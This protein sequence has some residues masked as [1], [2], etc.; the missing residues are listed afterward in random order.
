MPP[1]VEPP[2]GPA[3]EPP[4]RIYA[5]DPSGC[6]DRDDAFSI[7]PDYV[8]VYI[9]DVD[10][11]VRADSAYDKIIRERASSLYSPLTGLVHHMLAVDA[12][13][14]KND[15]WLVR[16]CSLT[17]DDTWKAVLKVELAAAGLRDQPSL[18]SISVT[19]IQMTRTLSYEG[20][21]AILDKPA[22]Q[23]PRWAREFQTDLKQLA[24]WTG[25]SE[26][27]ELV[28]IL[29]IATNRVVGQYLADHGY[30]LNRVCRREPEAAAGVGTEMA[31][32][33]AK[34]LAR[35]PAAYYSTNE[36]G[37]A[38]LGIDY[39]THFTSPMRRYPDLLAH[40]LV[41]GILAGR[42]VTLDDGVINSLN[43]QLRLIKRYY[44]K[45]TEH[46]LYYDLKSRETE[47]LIMAYPIAY[48]AEKSQLRL[49]CPEGTFQTSSRFKEVV[50]KSTLFGPKLRELI[51]VT[52]TADSIS[53][54]AEGHEIQIKFYQPL[55]CRVYAM[56]GDAESTSW[57]RL[58]I[59]PV[60]L[61][62]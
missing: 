1:P 49:Y 27:H 10:H 20:A 5:I 26:V 17:T 33:C 38:P 12:D 32:V 56:S 40:R 4:D 41:K 36:I 16:R 31:E 52:V 58:R 54:Q 24:D 14:T 7:G 34:Y 19:Q 62:R 28:A 53:L 15:D 35:G 22:G 37:H 2:A 47:L 48:N 21:Q 59:R 42:P 8:N 13:E 61:S 23:G 9:S 46:A 43:E 18:R 29:M 50:L 45:A 11:Y 44:R 39:Y 57:N 6:E 3:V 55:C 30:R 60:Y 25:V 51:K